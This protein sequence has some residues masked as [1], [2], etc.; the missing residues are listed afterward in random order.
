ME[1]HN[2]YH[3]LIDAIIDI[4]ED[5]ESRDPSKGFPRLLCEYFFAEETSEN[6][7]I[8][9]YIYQLPVPEVIKQKGLLH[10]TPDDIAPLVEGE[11][12]NDTLCARIMLQPAYLK[13]AYPHHSPS[14]SKMPPEIKGE[15]IKSIKERNQMILKAFE[16]MQQDIQATKERN[17][18][19]LIALIL[20]NVHL[21]TGMPFAKIPEPVGQLIEKNFNFCNETF[22]AS[23]KQ[24]HEINDDTKIKNLLKSLFIVKRFDDLVELAQVFKS[25]AKRFTRRTQRILQ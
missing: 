7:A 16:K 3:N 23:N 11:N 25:E 17:V 1:T 10:I 2:T 15:L 8:A 9:G 6:K 18:K 20:K 14:F 4:E 5:P 21:K 12:L 22:I 13:Y 19:T 24:I